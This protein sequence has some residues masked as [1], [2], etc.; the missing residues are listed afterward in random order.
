VNHKETYNWTKTQLELAEMQA[1]ELE[2]DNRVVPGSVHVWRNPI[3]MKI[4]VEWQTR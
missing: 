4:D 2:E 1:M 3:T